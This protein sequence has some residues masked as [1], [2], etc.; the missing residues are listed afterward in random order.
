MYV[1]T[2]ATVFSSRPINIIKKGGR[3]CPPR[4]IFSGFFFFVLN[5]ERFKN[6]TGSRSVEKLRHMRTVM[7]EL[8]AR[9]CSYFSVLF[10]WEGVTDTLHVVTC[11]ASHF[12]A[13]SRLI[14]RTIWVR[15]HQDP[16]VDQVL[17][18]KNYKIIPM[19]TCLRSLWDLG[20]QCNILG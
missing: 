1:C 3:Y 8:Q 19:S 5:I 14:H 12:H 7:E 15:R 16:T 11:H 17:K 10:V 9:S 18:K 2:R 20:S 4:V 13:Q 6:F